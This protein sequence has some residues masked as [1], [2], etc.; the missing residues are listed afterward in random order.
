[1]KDFKKDL[2][3]ARKYEEKFSQ[4]Y[5]QSDLNG[6]VTWKDEKFDADYEIEINGR[7][8]KAEIKIDFTKHNNF[9]IE[10]FSNLESGRLGGPLQ[11]L[12][13]G[14]KFF[15]YWFVSEFNKHQWDC[16]VFDTIKLINWME[17]YGYDYR[18]ADVHN[19]GYVTRGNIVPIDILASQPFCKKRRIK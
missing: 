3:K 12:K 16:Y 7:K 6:H 5:N 18:Y 17:R 4:L 13:Y 19:I 1:M 10:H 8:F 2:E 15:I 14:A 11:A 9:F